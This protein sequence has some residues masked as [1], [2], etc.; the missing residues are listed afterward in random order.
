MIHNGTMPPVVLDAKRRVSTGLATG[1][2]E[3]RLERPQTHSKAEF[4]KF[5]NQILFFRLILF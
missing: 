3:G 1:F 5:F 4:Y 2:D